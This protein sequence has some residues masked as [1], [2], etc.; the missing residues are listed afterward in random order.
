[1][2]GREVYG[3]RGRQGWVE[4]LGAWTEAAR[5][6]LWDEPRS[7][8]TAFLGRESHEAYPSLRLL[9]VNMKWLEKPI[10]DSPFLSCIREE[11]ALGGSSMGYCM[12]FSAPAL[13]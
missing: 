12:R 10:R 7:R 4:V 1:M 5:A 9:A 8:V 6:V 13:H 3:G 11:L 2:P